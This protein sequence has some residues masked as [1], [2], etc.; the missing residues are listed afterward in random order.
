MQC[1]R[2]DN[3]IT[4]QNRDPNGRKVRQRAARWKAALLSSE[5]DAQRKKQ[6][7]HSFHS[8]THSYSLHRES[9]YSRKFEESC[10]FRMSDDLFKI[11]NCLGL[12]ELSFYDAVSVGTSG[13]WHML[14]SRLYLLHRISNLLVYTPRQLMHLDSFRETLMTMTMTASKL[15]FLDIIIDILTARKTYISLKNNT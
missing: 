10:V 8:C 3:R 5:T 1:F 14:C 4:E 12:F 7:R 6:V 9:S 11:Y 13:G 2:Y 15:R